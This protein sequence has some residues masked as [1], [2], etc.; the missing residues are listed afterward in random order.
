MQ[1]PWFL[2][3]LASLGAVRFV[4]A[5]S[6]ASANP[7]S[8]T[9]SNSLVTGAG[10]SPLAAPGGN[11]PMTDDEQANAV[12]RLTEADLAA[13]AEQT[14]APASVVLPLRPNARSRG[15]GRPNGR[16]GDGSSLV[17]DSRP[18]LRVLMIGNSYTMHHTL[19]SML[20]RLAAS[21]AQG[22]QITVD[23]QVHGGYSLRNHLRTRGALAKIRSGRYTH[24]VLQ[25]HSLSALDHKDELEA[26]A[27]RFKQAID[28][29][30][31]HTVFY[32]TWARSPE[33]RIYLRH[34]AVHSFDQMSK[35]VA[36]TYSDISNRL[37]AGLAPVGSAFERALV[38]YPKL[39]LWGADGSHPSLAG[40]YLA[41]CVL[42][43]AISG[44]DPRP[45]VYA[46]P[47][48]PALEAAQIRELAAESFGLK[49]VPVV[50]TDLASSAL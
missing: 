21:V 50:S 16:R 7:V 10:P 32:A 5:H 15:A 14:P 9:I 42:Y 1:A 43:I 46:P 44:S 38:R 6:T 11:T 34:P 18:E 27:E 45:A 39:S 33:A 20:Q 17:E 49:P 31:G 35:L 37:G 36:S 23:A 19:H 28:A 26:D 13:L 22:P 4:S 12:D 25:G 47:G 24:V 3:V 41:A 8:G 30:E 48:L 40:S 2:L 29:A